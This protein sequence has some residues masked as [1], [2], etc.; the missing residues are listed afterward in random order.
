MKMDLGWDF[1]T[2]VS[3]VKHDEWEIR[4][5]LAHMGLMTD[6]QQGRSAV[7]KE[8]TEF[9]CA[10][11]YWDADDFNDT[12]PEAFLKVRPDEVA[13]NEKAM[14][15]AFLKFTRPID[16]RD[17]ALEQPNWY[18]G[19]DWSLDWAQDVEKNT[20]YTRQLEYINT[21]GGHHGKGE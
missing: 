10:M 17:G 9:H 19:A 6:T 3:A 14:I 13:F 16:S 20:R 12:K 11:V 7:R 2:F 4:E 18:P 15:C 1:S 8:I 21:F 5:I